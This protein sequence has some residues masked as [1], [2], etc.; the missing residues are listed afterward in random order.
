MSCVR[1]QQH[2]MSGG[3][4]IRR[5]SLTT[6]HSLPSTTSSSVADSRR[7]AV[8]R[9]TS[10]PHGYNVCCIQLCVFI[11]VADFIVETLPKR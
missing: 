5:N 3:E 7:L 8:G 2:V 6:L 9:Q 1:V 11:S 4:R 10:V